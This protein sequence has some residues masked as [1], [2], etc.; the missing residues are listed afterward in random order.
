MIETSTLSFAPGVLVKNDFS[1]QGNGKLD[2]FDG[3]IPCPTVITEITVDGQEDADGIVHVSYTY[4]GEAYQVKYRID[5]QGDYAYAVADLTLDI[6]GLAIGDHDIEIIPVC[7]NG[8]EG[9]GM[10]QDFIVTQAQT[11]STVISSITV[12]TSAKTA[13]AVVSVSGATQMKYRID[14]GAWIS[15]LI[16]ATISLSALSPGS[17]TIEMVPVCSNG[18]S[19]TGAT[20]TFTISSSP[21][22]S[23]INYDYENHPPNNYFDLYVN[24]VLVISLSATNGSGM[25]T[26][27][28]GQTVKVVLASTLTPSDL[29]NITLDITDDTTS[30]SIYSAST[31]NPDALTHSFVADGDEYTITATIDP[32]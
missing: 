10:D 20:N 32:I 29:R 11:C 24:G 16:T 14:G 3:L 7:T 26:A 23:I 6:P 15:A 5:G 19:G 2:M 27:P 30:T 9:T 8:Y 31:V 4:T 28:V 21:V 1:M 25:I 22:Q 17:H 13:V 12:D 18:V